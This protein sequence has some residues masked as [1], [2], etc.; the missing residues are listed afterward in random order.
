MT[1]CGRGTY[2]SKGV[3]VVGGGIN[4]VVVDL[5]SCGPKFSSLLDDLIMIGLGLE[6]LPL[7][8]LQP[9]I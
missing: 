4:L 6:L 1:G 2:A 3:K 9:I 5:F 8:D 7:F